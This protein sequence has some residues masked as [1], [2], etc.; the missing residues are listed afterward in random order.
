M[1]KRLKR[2]L[3]RL[4][5]RLIDHDRITPRVDQEAFHDWAAESFDDKGF[6]SYID[7][8]RQKLLAVIIT[9]ISREDYIRRVGQIYELDVLYTSCEKAF[10]KRMSSEKKAKEDKNKKKW[11]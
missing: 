3:I 7:D 5:L 11:R 8:R 2:V 9:G 4:L 10:Q 6:L 1:K